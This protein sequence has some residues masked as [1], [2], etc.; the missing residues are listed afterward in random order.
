MSSFGSVTPE[1]CYTVEACEAI[2]AGEVQALLMLGANFVRVVP[3]Y[4]QMGFAW[5]TLRLTVNVLTKKREG[6]LAA[7]RLIDITLTSSRFRSLA[8]PTRHKFD[9]LRSGALLSS[10]R[11]YRGQLWNGVV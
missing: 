11:N 10:D 3:D 2:L 6:A 7:P 8:V 4:G 5:R 1:V 9:R